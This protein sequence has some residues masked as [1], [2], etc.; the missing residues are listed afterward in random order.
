MQTRRDCNVSLSFYTYEYLTG[1]LHLLSSKAETLISK[2]GEFY[3]DNRVTQKCPLEKEIIRYAL[4]TILG[5]YGIEKIKGIE[6]NRNDSFDISNSRKYP[7]PFQ[8]YT[9]IGRLQGELDPE[10]NLEIDSSVL[11][12][13][14]L[15]KIA[16][17]FD[18][19]YSDPL[20]DKM[21]YFH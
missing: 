8:F 16:L 17:F 12:G 13:K 6:K 14:N 3:E 10:R 20:T 4:N 7:Y 18:S 19:V 11:N 5:V 21:D 9:F 2:L 1:Y 15:V